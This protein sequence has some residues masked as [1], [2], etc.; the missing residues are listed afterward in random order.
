MQRLEYL[1]FGYHEYSVS[2]PR[3]LLNLAIK[4]DRTARLTPKNTVIISIPSSRL[5]KKELSDLG[6]TEIGAPRGIGGLI[7]QIPSH[8]PM[9]ILLILALALYILSTD[10]VF[11]V[12]VS[13]NEIMSEQQVLDEL[14]AVGFG[15]GSRWS[16]IDRNAI[17][18]SVLKRAEGIAWININREGRVAYVSVIELRDIPA[19][20]PTFTAA[21][22]VATEDCVI[23]EITVTRGTPVVKVGDTVRAGDLLISGIVEGDRGTE[24][25]MAEGVVRGSSSL[26]IETKIDREYTE[27]LPREGALAT[28]TLKIFDFDIN[29]LQSYGNLSEE[30]V[31]IEEK[32]NIALFGRRLPASI[33]RGKY[34]EYESI[35]RR[36]SDS[37]LVE[38]ITQLHR[39]DINLALADRDLISIR[40]DGRFTDGGYVFE[41]L[42][43]YS[44]AVGRVA[45]IKTEDI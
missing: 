8:I 19:P 30:C 2:D 16:K 42:L 40:T 6:A 41:S 23:E 43:V 34:V 22:I 20:P 25:V 21:N 5:M 13:G 11:D 10:L 14:S 29:I 35:T 9:V 7:S 27:S 28:L 45:E 24:Y 39:E 38:M 36:L 32:R 37:E 17:E 12:R 1:I 44:A 33:V 18:L 31:I 15:V 26:S 4:R 3:T